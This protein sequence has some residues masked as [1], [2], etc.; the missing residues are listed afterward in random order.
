ML[1][2][3]VQATL[4]PCGEGRKVWEHW[5]SEVVLA[6]TRVCVVN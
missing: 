2:S 5:F 1:S 4:H 6:T 3:F